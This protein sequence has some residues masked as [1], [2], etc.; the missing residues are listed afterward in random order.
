MNDNHIST[1]AFQAH[2]EQA[3]NAFGSSEQAAPTSLANLTLEQRFELAKAQGMA[4]AQAKYSE[5]FAEQ[6]V[7]DNSIADQMKAAES[8]KVQQ[9]SDGSITVKKGVL[10][11][12][13]HS[14]E[15]IKILRAQAYQRHNVTD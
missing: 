8:S 13:K 9:H 1:D 3:T 11:N 2:N 14:A 15:L 6:V 7:P 5:L 12:D 4:N 10:G